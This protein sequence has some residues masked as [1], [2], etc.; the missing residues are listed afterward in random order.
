MENVEV[1]SVAWAIRKDGTVERVLSINEGFSVPLYSVLLLPRVPA[2]EQGL[3]K[4]F[5]WALK[6][7]QQADD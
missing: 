6:V 7:R 1:G 2:A 3:G 5:Q 4:L